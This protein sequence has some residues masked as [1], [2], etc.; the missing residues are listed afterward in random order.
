MFSHDEVTWMKFIGSCLLKDKHM[1]RLILSSWETLVET[2][3]FFIPMCS[4][5]GRE[6]ES[7]SSTS[8]LIQQKIF[9][10]ILSYGIPKESCK[11]YIFLIILKIFAFL[12]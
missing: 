12:H 10:L 3:I 2:L 11:L 7:S 8:G 5:K 6:T 1:M 9:I 4:P